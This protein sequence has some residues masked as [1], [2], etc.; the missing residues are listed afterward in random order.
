MTLV[1]V[2]TIA[3]CA[4]LALYILYS[5]IWHAVRRGLREFHQATPAHALRAP[6]RMSIKVPDY[7][8]SEWL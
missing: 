2:A 6:R 5:V 1:T 4:S 8:P 3:I 7:P